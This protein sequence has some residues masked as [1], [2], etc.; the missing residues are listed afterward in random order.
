MQLDGS[1]LVLLAPADAAP[2]GIAMVAQEIAVAPEM[3]VAENIALGK[4]PKKGL[5]LNKAGIRRDAEA[6]LRRLSATIP[7]DAIAGSLRPSEQRIV[8]IAAALFHDARLVIMDEPTA[9]MG[10]READDVLKVVE[11]MAADGVTIIY[12]S[13]R[14]DEVLRVCT[15]VSVMRDGRHLAD[16]HGDELNRGALIN[17]IA[18]ED[19]L[20][21]SIASRA[22]VFRAT[23]DGEPLVRM[24]GISATFLDGFEFEAHAGEVVGVIGTLESGATEVLEVLA[25]VLQPAAGRIAID[26]RY[27]TIDSPTDAL[28]VGVG[29]LSGGRVNSG[30]REQPV[31]ENISLSRHDKVANAAHVV[32]RPR[33]RNGVRPYADRFGLASRID[34]NL[35]TL[36]GGNQQKIL[37]A[38]L[39]FA[40]SRILVLEDPTLGVDVAAR[41][42]LLGALREVADEGRLVLIYTSEPPELIGHADRICVLRG[43][44]IV[45]Q[46]RDDQLTESVIARE[47][48]GFA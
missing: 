15:T 2:L 27:R 35:L 25:G 3:T 26:G 29:Y 31:R 41:E 16:L 37:L 33:E 19:G 10:L 45:S 30:V 20:E 12:V 43:G 39:L 46:L 11:Q 1:P 5:L 34:D 6:A 28:R 21:E 48:A 42:E 38:R 44:R 7:L 13:H 36:S 17:A 24:E 4:E 8:M 40:E 23:K 18:T 22:G 9:G 32:T 47:T 14:L